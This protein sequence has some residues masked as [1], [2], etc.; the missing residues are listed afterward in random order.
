MV[1]GREVWEAGAVNGQSSREWFPNLSSRNLPEPDASWG[2][3]C[4]LGQ[5][6]DLWVGGGG[7]ASSQLVTDLEKPP[8]GSPVTQS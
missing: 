7:A 2:R 3:N 1:L 4:F 8:A 6:L 5:A